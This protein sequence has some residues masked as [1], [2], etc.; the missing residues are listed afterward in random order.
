MLAIIG[1]DTKMVQKP[2][3]PRSKHLR[4]EA[5]TSSNISLSTVPIVNL[6]QHVRAC[7]SAI[8]TRLGIWCHSRNLQ[9]SSHMPDTVDLKN[10]LKQIYTHTWMTQSEKDLYILWVSSHDQSGC[11]RII[12]DMTDTFTDKCQE[13]VSRLRT[14]VLDS[15]PGALPSHKHE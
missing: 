6:T 13:L 4:V 9:S 8:Q 14:H 11:A 2:F 10:Q 3:K 15:Y 1:S 7:H 5:C 12:H